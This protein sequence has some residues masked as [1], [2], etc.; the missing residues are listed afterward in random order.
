MTQKPVVLIGAPMDCGKRRQGCRMGPDAYRVA[1]IRDAIEALGIPVEDAGDVQPGAP[2]APDLPDHVHAGAEVIAWTKALTDTSAAASSQG[3]PVF[4]GGDHAISLGTVAGVAAHAA[5]QGR[6]LFLLWLDAHPD[7]H[8]PHT[9]QSGNLHG[10]PV[11]YA[12]GR[13]GFDSFPEMPNVSPQNVA[14]LGL[15]SVD[16]EERLEL[17][18]RDFRLYDMRAIDERGI[19]GCLQPFLD[20]VAAANG[21]LHVSLDVDFL[22]PGIAPAV[23]TTVP[24]GATFR[25]AHL[26]MELISESGLMSSL[27]LVELN[28]MLDRQ[29]ET[30]ALM[31]DL[32]TSLFGKRIFDR[33]TSGRADF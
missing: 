17:Q 30:A 33:P 3:L 7:Y 1:G 31:I 16:P 24:G 25:E 28:P 19:A 20:D 23:G 13:E 6:P 12:T 5:S 15:R 11:G 10:T 9:T 27:D 4:L 8:S 18:A 21:L 26:A 22:D 2:I 32:V 29:G 14:L